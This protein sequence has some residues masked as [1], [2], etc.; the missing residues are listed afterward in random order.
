MQYMYMHMYSDYVL[1]FWMYVHIYNVCST[2]VLLVSMRHTINWL[3]ND[4]RLINRP[5]MHRRVTVVGSLCLCVCLLHCKSHLTSGVSVY[6][7]N[8]VKYSTGNRGQKCV[9]KPLQHSLYWK[10][11]VQS[12]IFLRKAHVHYSIYHVVSGL[13]GVSCVSWVAIDQSVY[14][15]MNSWHRGFCTLVHSLITSLYLPCMCN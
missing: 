13:C 12:A 11:Y 2:Y 10:P 3:R 4:T 5:R 1:L 14:N 8:S 6:P 15:S 9:L 7:Q